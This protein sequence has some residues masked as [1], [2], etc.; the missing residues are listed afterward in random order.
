MSGETRETR[1]DLHVFPEV[2]QGPIIIP[3]FRTS[4]TIYP[5]LPHFTKTSTRH[6]LLTEMFHLFQR[7]FFDNLT[8][9]TII[10]VEVE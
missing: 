5:N 1:T 10:P 7:L 8:L 6:Y 2:P 4:S 3:I 9:S